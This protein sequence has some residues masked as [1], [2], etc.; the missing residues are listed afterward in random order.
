MKGNKEKWR[1]NEWKYQLSMT[2]YERLLTLGNEQGVL[3]KELPGWLGWLDDVRWVGHLMWWAWWAMGDMLYV[4]NLNSSQLGPWIYR[5]SPFWP[6]RSL[7]RGLLLTYY[8]SPIKFRDPLYLAA[9]RIFSLSL[10][11]GS[12]TMKHQGVE[13]LPLI[14]GEITLSA[15][16]ACLIP[17]PS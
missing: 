7:W 14:M 10:E 8:F 13:R 9:L 4:G 5:A 17:S 12:F 16:C 15:G 3:E 11:F 2:E 1:E 6:S